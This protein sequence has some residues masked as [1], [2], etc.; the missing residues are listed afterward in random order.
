MWDSKKL[1]QRMGSEEKRRE[2][3]SRVGGVAG[4]R[5]NLLLPYRLQAKEREV[6]ASKH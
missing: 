4:S 6:K 2:E 3:K 1:L 5:L